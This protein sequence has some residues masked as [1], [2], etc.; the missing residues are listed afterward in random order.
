[1]RQWVLIGAVVLL[2]ALVPGSGQ[3]QVDQCKSRDPDVAVA[4]CSK[5]LQNPRVVGKDRAVTYG[6]R[7]LAYVH[8]GM[9]DE[10]VADGSR[11][12]EVD[13]RSAVGYSYRAYIFL[14]KPDDDRAFAD[15]ERALQIDPRSDAAIMCAASC[16][17]GGVSSIAP[18]PTSRAP[19][20]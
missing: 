11:A 14:R 17:R 15:A 5:L 12:V 7:G 4:G 13:P 2:P 10:A 16:C 18:S 9:I 6:L 20:S 8:K 1:M 19:I 3:A